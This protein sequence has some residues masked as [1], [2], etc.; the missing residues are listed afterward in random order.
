MT[1]AAYRRETVHR[2]ASACE[3]VEIRRVTSRPPPSSAAI[4]VAEEPV[5]ARVAFVDPLPPLTGID[6]DDAT[7]VERFRFAGHAEVEPSEPSEE[8][9]PSVHRAM[10]TIDHLAELKRRLREAEAR[11][12]AAAEEGSGIRLRPTPPEGVREDWVPAD[13]HF[14][15]LDID[16]VPMRARSEWAELDDTLPELEVALAPRSE[17]NFYGGFDNDAPDGVFVATYADLPIDTP[18]YVVVHLPAGY[19]FRT[20]ALVEFVREPAAASPEAPAGVGLRMCGLGATE[21][22]LIREFVRQRSPL[23]YVG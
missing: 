12:E 20:A 22:R 4:A 3:V 21:Q 9:A 16:V 2:A 13:D 11:E 7:R 6:G 23:F 17:S 19:Q 1:R 18:V 10:L 5:T 14:E 15:D 8:E